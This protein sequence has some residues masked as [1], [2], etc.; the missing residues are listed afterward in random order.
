MPSLIR[1]RYWSRW[2]VMGS[3]VL[4]ITVVDVLANAINNPG[5]MSYHDIARLVEDHL[6]TR[7]GRLAGEAEE[8]ERSARRA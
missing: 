8:A 4:G 1:A 2:L 6:N 7:I 5:A 3:M